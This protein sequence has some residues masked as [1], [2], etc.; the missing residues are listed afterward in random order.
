MYI[1]DDTE[2][3]VFAIDTVK[4]IETKITFTNTPNTL[5]YDNGELFVGFGSN[6]VVAILDS[7]T[8]EVKE[9]LIL[10]T[11]FYDVASGKDGNIYIIEN[12]GSSAFSY[13]RS[14][15]RATGQ[16]LSNASVYPR[17]GKFVPHPFHISDD[18]LGNE[19]PISI[20]YIDGQVIDDEY[21]IVPIYA[22]DGVV[23]LK[24]RPGNGDIFG[25]GVVDVKDGLRL[26]QYLAG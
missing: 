25:D 2:N 11:V 12:F 21:Q 15:S 9:K 3:A 26:A 24:P 19:I 18:A 10:G 23:K 17:N 6:G 7:Q 13:A 20:Y 8:L 16:Q 4:M 22:Q 5:Y 1:A 14:Y